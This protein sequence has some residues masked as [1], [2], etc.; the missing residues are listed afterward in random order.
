[1]A[2]LSEEPVVVGHAHMLKHTDRHNAIELLFHLPVIK[3]LK[4]HAVRN[5]G[6]LGLL[7]RTLPLLF[8]QRD[9]RYTHT[10][11][12]R[13]EYRETAPAAADIQHRHA[14]FQPELGS[15]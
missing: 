10:A 5:T 12:L 11:L 2:N 15:D 14:R 1:M 6:V 7:L 4:L 3:E 9:P 8:G 13:E